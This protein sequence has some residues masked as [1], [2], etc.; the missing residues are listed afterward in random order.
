MTTEQ[1]RPIEID[2][3]PLPVGAALRAKREQLGWSLA[4]VAA[5]LRIKLSYL[6]ALEGG[7]V[8][9]LPGNAYAL[10][11]LRAYSGVL[12]L[13]AE[14]MSR[15]F[16]HETKDVN[17]RPELSF[18][19]PVP[20]RGVPAGAVVLL[21]V[22]VVVAAYAGWY[23]FSGHERRAAHAVPPVPAGLLAYV[24]PSGAPMTSPQVA[25]VM[26]G[27]G[28]TPSPLAV[29][30]GGAGAAISGTRTAGA[31]DGRAA[32]PDAAAAKRAAVATTAPPAQAA[33]PNSGAVAAPAAPASGTG[34]A[35][36][37]AV[38]SAVA[39]TSGQIVIQAVA[40]SWV[41][42]REVGGKV[43][44]DHVLKPG[45][46]W[47]VPQDPAPLT[48][49]TGNAGGVTL[50]VDGVTSPVL[51][52]V[53]AVRR[54]VPLSVQAVKDG[55]IAVAAPASAGTTAGT[56]AGAAADTPGQPVA[57]HHERPRQAVVPAQDDT[58]E[59][60]NER[61]LKRTTPP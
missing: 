12:G 28:Q 55:S 40:S 13:D 10:G 25:T 21:G 26:P 50:A 22:V 44:Y 57:V 53:G 51:G 29:P 6:E 42:V 47:T 37:P 58:T 4:D 54:A 18:P 46:S 3:G 14:E 27:P 24:G 39:S 60:L 31:A 34:A 19:A 23:E 56:D 30:M 43:I 17:R 7:Q 20:E 5:W 8:A 33:A 2:P 35:T 45:E 59:K 32:P 48:L 38:A 15:R 16:R 52:R 41:Q 1:A 9:K 49:S 11:F 61:Q 36:P